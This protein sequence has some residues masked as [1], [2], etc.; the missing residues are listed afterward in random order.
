MSRTTHHGRGFLLLGCLLVALTTSVFSTSVA[1]AQA[2]PCSTNITG[3]ESTAVLSFSSNDVQPGQTVNILGRGF[4]P[5]TEV[6]LTVGGVAIGVATTD[7]QG[8]FTFPYTIPV[9]APTGSLQV[10]TTCG[11]FVLTSNLRVQIASNVITNPP[12]TISSG[13]L[14]V[15]GSSLT[16]PLTSLAVVLIVGGGLL[17]LAMRRRTSDP[18]TLGV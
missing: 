17:V 1:S 9:N 7:A 15:T 6:P 14:V 2:V 16:V 8:N 12:T 13:N 10:A 11:A 4:P 18:S 3:Y 5:G